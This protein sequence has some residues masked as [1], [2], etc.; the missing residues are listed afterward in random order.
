[1]VQLYVQLTMYS[2]MKTV[3]TGIYRWF[4]H[5]CFFNTCFASVFVGYIYKK[6]N[7]SCVYVLLLQHTAVTM[8][9]TRIAVLFLA[10]VCTLLLS[11]SAPTEA[12]S[13]RHLLKRG[14][15]RPYN[16]RMVCIS[17]VSDKHHLEYR[18]ATRVVLAT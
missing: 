8:S 5:P 2:C 3:P 4:K 10:T 1:V 6:Y 12:V 7:V 15:D 16:Y 17:S 9:S 14:D 13:G 11:W 18:L